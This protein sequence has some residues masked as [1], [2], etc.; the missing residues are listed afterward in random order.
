MP[1]CP[2]CG[3]EFHEWGKLTY[4]SGWEAKNPF[5]EGFKVEDPFATTA[6]PIMEK[7]NIKPDGNTRK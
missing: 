6:L 5:S 4:L 1:I 3:F 2:K 7:K